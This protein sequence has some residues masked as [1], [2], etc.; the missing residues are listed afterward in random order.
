MNALPATLLV[1]ACAASLW[2]CACE[3]PVVSYRLRFPSEE[4][5]LMSS[6]LRVEVYDGSGENDESPDAICRALSVGQP[7]PVSTMQSTGKRD[8]CGFL[9]PEGL[10]IENVDT[11]RLVLFA[12]AEDEI[13]TSL[14]RGC[15]VVDVLANTTEVEIQL[16][17]LPTYPDTPTP[18]CPN[19]QAKCESD[20]C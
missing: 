12:E 2:L 11:G 18:S 10:D 4:T 8:V 20:S 19:Q 7:A 16:S 17:T 9:G 15:T 5:F 3:P 14:L 1:A 6:T 13:G